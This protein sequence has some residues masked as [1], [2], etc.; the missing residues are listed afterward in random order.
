MKPT[1]TAM[2]DGPT[3]T[4]VHTTP[5][6]GKGIVEQPPEGCPKPTRAY[7]KITCCC[8]SACCWDRCAWKSPPKSCLVGAAKDAKWVMDKQKGY[9]QAVLLRRPTPSPTPSF[10][11]PNG[12]RRSASR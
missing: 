11:A 1:T 10:D 5:P 7:G 12:R 3:T 8:G 6:A 4:P 2:G 9:Y